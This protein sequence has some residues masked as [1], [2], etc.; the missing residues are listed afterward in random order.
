MTTKKSPVMLLGGSGLGPWAWT[1]VAGALSQSGIS[2]H[3]PDLTRIDTTQHGI[4][5]WRDRILDDMAAVEGPLTLVA[6]SF[7]GYVAAGVL[8]A[9]P[10]GVRRLV[11][12]DA[13]LPEPDRSFFDS[14]GAEAASFMT[15][16]AVPG[17]HGP[18][19]PWFTAEQLDALYP[20][21]GMSA[22]TVA[23]VRSLASPQPLSTYQDAPAHQ[24]LSEHDV[25]TTYIRCRHTPAPTDVSRLPDAWRVVELEA[26]HWP[27]FTAADQ[28]AATLT[29][30]LP[31]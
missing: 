30:V 8:E 19:V 21:H 23:W 9:R 24:S 26:G 10:T 27:M 29:E 18:V 25:P 22:E 5:A 16:L 15:S 4:A 7:A 6:H 20:G 12:L 13:V 17:P 28:L 3:L 11:L 1:A 2:V 14:A 31:S